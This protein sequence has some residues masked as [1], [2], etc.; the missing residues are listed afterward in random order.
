MNDRHK[1]LDQCQ[2]HVYLLDLNVKGACCYFC[3]TFVIVAGWLYDIV[4][5]PQL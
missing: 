4:E 5:P 3:E 2:L 1:S